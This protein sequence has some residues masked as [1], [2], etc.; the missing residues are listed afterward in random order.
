MNS[1]FHIALIAASAEIIGGH[2]V[3]A[4]ALATQLSADGHEVSYIPIDARFPRGLRWVRRLRYVRTLLN[5]L[6]YVLSLRR[7]V[8]ADVV[9]VFSAS[10]WSFLLGPAPAIVAAKLL[11]KPVILHYHSGEADDHLHRWR[12]IV[13]PFLR[14]VNEI[15]V[16]SSYL[17]RVFASHGYR[18]RMIPNCV[19]TSRFPYRERPIPGPRLLSARNLE[20]HYRVDITI[21]AFALLKARFPEASLMIAGNGTEE[22]TLRAFVDQLGVSGIRFLGS[23]DPDAMPKT[24]DAADIFVNSSLVDNQ[25]VSILEAFASGLPVVSTSTGDIESMLRGGEAGLLV[26]GE[27]AA[28][29]ADAVTR[30]L[31]EPGLAVRIARRAREEAERYTWRRVG[32]DWKTL[33]GELL[34]SHAGEALAHGA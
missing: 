31:D 24:Y 20:R 34:G 2:S 30:L 3:Q 16:P 14:I 15:V 7:M 1:P 11:R 23:V 26:G 18:A 8:R 25:P 4:R 12:R 19:E 33:Y 32:V 13:R 5:E 21:N 9:H 29:V 27:D 22:R 6:L 28:A 10:Y 17:E